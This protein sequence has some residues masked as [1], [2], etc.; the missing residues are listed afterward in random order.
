MTLPPWSAVLQVLEAHGIQAAGWPADAQEL[1]RTPQA[2]ATFL[3]FKELAKQQPFKTYQAMLD[4]L[5]KEQILSQQNGP[6]ISQLAGVIAE[7]MAEKETL[8][9]AAARF[10]EHAHDLDVL[11]ASGIL[12]DFDGARRR[13]GFSHQTVFEHALARSFAQKEGRLSTFVRERQPSLFIRPKLW[14]AL[15]YLRDVEPPAYDTELQA[16]WNIQGLR[17]HL[18]NLL[19]E[20]LGQQSTP[21][22]TETVL[23]E[24]VLSSADRRVALQAMI[25]SS[26]WLDLFGPTHVSTAMVNKDEANLAA[27]ILEKAWSFAPETVTSLIEKRWLHEATFD[28]YT[29]TVL[30]ESTVWNDALVEIAKT[31]LARTEIS[32]FAFERLVSTVGVEQPEVALK[33]VSARLAAQLEKATKESAIRAALPPPE[34][35]DPLFQRLMRTAPDTPIIEVITQQNGWDELEA[36]AKA[37]P[38]LFLKYIWPWFHQA[39]QTLIELKEAD[40]D[41]PGFPLRYGLDLRFPEE[42]SLGLS[43]PPLLGSLVA[44]VEALASGDPEEF[45][46]WLAFHEGENATP[47]QRIFAHSLA[48]QPEKFA[49]RA[50]KFLLDDTNRFHLGS[51]EDSS[52]TT[53]RLVKAVSPFWN[54]GT[55]QAFEKR[56]SSLFAT[57]TK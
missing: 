21:T 2:L 42:H 53:K 38:A 7:G 55:L 35:K 30:Q 13:I 45:L 11:I 46:S 36:L 22:A 26:G 20:F 44:A 40:S 50:A 5:W 33:L 34:G 8:W 52:G 48:S 37:Y 57:N 43:E 29:W 9:L 41:R 49:E 10:E 47:A 28:I 14:A 51:I 16:I 17:R 6:R 18:K 19:I 15:T 3:K 27:A 39:L 4:Q 24:Q 25:G 12:T 54:Q 56:D 31:V 23:M 1:L 32:P